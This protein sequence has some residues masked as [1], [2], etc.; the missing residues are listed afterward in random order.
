MH[1]QCRRR[2]KPRFDPWVGKI[3]WRWEWQPT[4]LFLPRESHGQRSLAGYSP[5]DRK[6]LDMTEATEHAC[7]HGIY[8]DVSKCKMGAWEPGSLP[9]GGDSWTEPEGMWA[10]SQENGVR[11]GPEK[12]RSLCQ[13]C[14]MGWGVSIWDT[15]ALV[16]MIKIM[17]LSGKNI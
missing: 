5:C 7:M 8:N 2:R 16:A 4:P 10:V 15:C 1:L 13:E 14:R 6:E 17:F 9:G 11:S 12:G 3:P